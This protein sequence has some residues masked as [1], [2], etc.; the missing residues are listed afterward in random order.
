[1]S[2]CK[3]NF[4]YIKDKSTPGSWRRGYECFQK[5]L[6]MST[7]I[8][9]NVLTSYVKGNFK[10]A[11][12]VK[13]EFKKGSVKA[14]C[15]CPLEEEWCKHAIAVGLDTIE[16][17]YYDEFLEEKYKVPQ[18]FSDDFVEETQEPQGGYVFHFN[19]KRRQNF[20]SI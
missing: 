1:M 4:K 2:V 16:H 3:F 19:P 15:D 8:K 18:D 11:Y 10:D 9:K 5:N 7:E 12:E 17:G 6:I 20:F 13:L 14:K